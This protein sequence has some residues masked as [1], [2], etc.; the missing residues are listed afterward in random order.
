VYLVKVMMAARQVVY[1]LTTGVAEAG[2]QRQ[3]RLVV[4][5]NPVVAVELARLTQSQDRQFTMLEVVVAPC[6]PL[7]LELS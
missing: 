5:M 2:L 3:V 6:N 1:L 4:P 7:G